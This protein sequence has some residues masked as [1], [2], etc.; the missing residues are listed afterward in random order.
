MFNDAHRRVNDSM[1]DSSAFSRVVAV[2]DDGLT[3]GMELN[4]LSRLMTTTDVLQ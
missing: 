1:I 3:A 2:A 4:D